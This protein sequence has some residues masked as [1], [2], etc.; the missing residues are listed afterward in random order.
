MTGPEI[1]P[2]MDAPR[3]DQ[4]RCFGCDE[5]FEPWTDE[6]FCSPACHMAAVAAHHPLAVRAAWSRPQPAHREL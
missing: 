2:R 3:V 5:M 6:W 4:V 1:E